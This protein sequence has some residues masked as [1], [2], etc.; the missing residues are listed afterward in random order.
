MKFRKFAHLALPAGTGLALHRTRFDSMTLSVR[1][2]DDVDVRHTHCV[3]AALCI[4]ARSVSL[5][6]F[7]LPGRGVF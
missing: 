6:A 1:G 3:D 2:R 5:P 4:S 7:R